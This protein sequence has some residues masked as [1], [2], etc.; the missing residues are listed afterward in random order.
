MISLGIDFGT[1]FTKATL[2]DSVERR[3]TRVALNSKEVDFGFGPTRYVMP[4]VVCVVDGVYFTGDEAVNSKLVCDEYFDNF[5]TV[6][7]RT[8]DVASP[9]LGITYQTILNKIFEHVRDCIKT[10]VTNIKKIVLTVPVSTVQEGNRWCRMKNAAQNVF[11][12]ALSIEIIPEPVAAGF[13][14]IGE[15]IKSDKSINGK[16]F[17]I[18][19]LGGGTFDATI[20]KVENGQIF[21]VGTSV[22]S[23]DE[24]K[25]GGIYIDDLIKRDYIINCPD[26]QQYIEN[27]RIG[28]SKVRYQLERYLRIEPTK[29]KIALST[30]S[31]Y[32]FPIGN[33]ILTQGH[34]ERLCDAMISDTIQSARSL[35]N[36]KVDE[37]YEITL[38]DIDTIFLVGGSSR[39]PVIRQKWEEQRSIGTSFSEKVNYQY[40]L[41]EC[42]LEVVATGAALYD[43]LK[44]TS[45]RLIKYGVR[46][47]RLGEYDKAALCFQNADNSY[48][49]YLLGIL[50]YK[51]LIGRKSN[52]RDAIKLFKQSQTEESYLLLGLM[53][54]QGGQ[55]M[56][57]NHVFAKDCLSKVS[58]SS[59]IVKDLKSAITTGNASEDSLNR[60]YGYDPLKTFIES[61]NDDEDSN[62]ETD[63]CRER[64]VHPCS[65]ELD[66]F[67]LMN[68]AKKNL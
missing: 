25:W 31:Q 7:E 29:A 60:I 28:D 6:L 67:N 33:Y 65:P 19:D 10:D 48:G 15:R 24:Q 9:D 63:F 50:Y 18:Y 61:Y 14:L 16:H 17:L 26:L 21:I 51:G 1:T 55:G 13:A 47:L 52:Y 46:H 41:C 44:I 53:S 37:C 2:Y 23:D 40:K 49:K 36:S 3:I 20:F 27:A 39:I 56:P 42:D 38:Q 43:S 59:Q 35:L 22:G 62:D 45:D 34:F 12:T 58:E 68:L 8:D 11:S 5:K 64:E 66:F 30:Q 54:F 57:R 32:T 4:S